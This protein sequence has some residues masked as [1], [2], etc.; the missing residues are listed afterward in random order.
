MA[1]TPAAIPDAILQKA[2]DLQR[3]SSK[4]SILPAHQAYFL[5]RTCI[6]VPKMNY[7]LRASPTWLCGDELDQ[8]DSVGKS[9]L[10][11][12]TNVKMDGLTWAQAS[13]P[14]SSGGLGIRRVAELATPAYLA[15]VYATSSV[16]SDITTATECYDLV[17]QLWQ[18]A[19]GA[20][21]PAEN[22]RRSQKVWDAALVKK[23]CEV[24]VNTFANDVTHCARL[25]AVAQPESGKWLNALPVPSLGTLMSDESFRVAVGLR[26]GAPIC[27][28]HLCTDCRLPVDEFGH[29]GLSCKKSA[30][31]FMRHSSLNEVIRRSLVTA[32][33]PAVL[34]PRGTSDVDERRP[35]GVSQLPWRNGRRL[36]WDVTCVDTLALSNVISSSTKAGEAAKKAEE[37][38]RRKYEYLA[39]EYD[40]VA[41]AFETF[42]VVG[43]ACLKFLRELGKRIMDATGERR[44]FEFLLQRLSIEI[45]RGNALSVTSTVP[46]SDGLNAVYFV[47]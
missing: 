20:E 13:L 21:L 14:V 28:S 26:I 15:S 23:T 45:Q 30:G 4:L 39:D 42:G 25:L 16:V 8:F 35:D 17:H 3:L 40:F 24:I 47:L 5:L 43:P 32:N 9:A 31:R 2:Q 19:S 22:V 38:K 36:A 44:S 12:V 1:T 34:E 18:T 46:R 41:L 33:T 29:H 6:C 11:A 10:E 7:L 27:S 37:E